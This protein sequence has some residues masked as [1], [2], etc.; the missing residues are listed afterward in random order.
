[1]VQNMNMLF[2]NGPRIVK[3]GDSGEFLDITRLLEVVMGSNLVQIVSNTCAG[4]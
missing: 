4:M 3:N 1:M 2:E